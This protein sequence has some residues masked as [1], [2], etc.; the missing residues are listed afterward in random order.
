MEVDQAGERHEADGEVEAQSDLGNDP[1][2]IELEIDGI[3]RQV[4][5][6]IKERGDAQHAPDQD[7]LRPVGD[8][9]EWRDCQ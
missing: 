7:E 3:E 1:Q 2:E 9:A 6:R 8:A 5:Q 4:H